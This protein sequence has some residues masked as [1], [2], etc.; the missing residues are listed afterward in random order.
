MLFLV[1]RQIRTRDEW[2]Q[3]R[4]AFLSIWGLSCLF[5][6]TWGLTFLD[7]GPFSEF[8]LFLSCILNSFQG[9]LLMLRFYM[10]EWIRKQAGGSGL[11]STSSGSTRQHMLQE[12]S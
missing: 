5:G 1:Y 3:N 10:L 4:V 9:F 7:F 6:I 11:G 2:K 12:K 8:A